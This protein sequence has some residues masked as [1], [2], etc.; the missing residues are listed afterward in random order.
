MKRY[1]NCTIN[2]FRAMIS[3]TYNNLLLQTK[4]LGKYVKT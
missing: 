3:P 2:E 1:L 4:S